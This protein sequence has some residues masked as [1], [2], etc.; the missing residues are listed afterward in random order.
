MLCRALLM[1]ALCFCLEPQMCQRCSVDVPGKAQKMFPDKGFSRPLSDGKQ[2]CLYIFEKWC[3][4]G[5][6]SLSDAKVMM[7]RWCAVADVTLCCLVLMWHY[8]S[9]I[10]SGKALDGVDFPL[11]PE[12]FLLHVVMLLMW[13]RCLPSCWFCCSKCG[14]WCLTR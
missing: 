11:R 5:C 9:M 4:L 1:A 13:N 2:M 6:L 3:E 14:C 7:Q 10:C 8:A 12:E